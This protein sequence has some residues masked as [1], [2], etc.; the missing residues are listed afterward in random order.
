MFSGFSFSTHY[1]L[2]FVNKQT[3]KI[4]LKISAGTG[5]P[6]VKYW[7]WEAVFYDSGGGIM[8]LFMST[9]VTGIDGMT[10]II[11]VLYSSVTCPLQCTAGMDSLF[12]DVIKLCLLLVNI[13]NIAC[14]SET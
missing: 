4:V 5:Y 8:L 10:R 14:I 2:V 13:L 3:G 1:R 11:A 9:F 12:G 7:Q 6:Y